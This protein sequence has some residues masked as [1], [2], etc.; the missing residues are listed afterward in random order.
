MGVER[1]NNIT[2]STVGYEYNDFSLENKKEMMAALKVWAKE[3]R[4]KINEQQGKGSAAPFVQA[5]KTMTPFFKQNFKDLQF[6]SPTQDFTTPVAGWW[7]DE[8]NAA[9]AP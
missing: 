4:Q 9:G 6:Y 2:D 5:V 8:A 7:D 1:V 3:T